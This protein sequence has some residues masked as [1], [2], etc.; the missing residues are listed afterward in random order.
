MAGVLLLLAGLLA[1]LVG[2]ALLVGS[3]PQRRLPAMVAPVGQVCECPPG[4]NP[5]KPGPVDQARPNPD[6]PAA[7]V[8]DRRAGRLVAVTS[9]ADAVETWTF[10]VCRNAWTRMHPDQEPAGL[11]EWDLFV[12]DVDSDVTVAVDRDDGPVWVYDLQADTWVRKGTGPSD[13]RLGAYDPV[14]GLVVVARDGDPPELWNYDVEA[15][16]WT[17][18]RLANGPLAEGWAGALAYDASVDQ[19]VAYNGEFTRLLNLRAGIWSTSGAAAPPVVGW[20]VAPTMAYDEAA[21]R[22]A[23]FLRVPLTAYD[24][25]ADRWVR[26]PDADSGWPHPG[27]P[28]PSRMVFD[29]VNRRLI[30]M[31][32][33]R[34]TPDID[35]PPGGVEALDLASG[36]RT[37]LLEPA[38]GQPAP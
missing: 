24:A 8:F 34:G 13:A 35:I 21:R 19:I 14:S 32:E 5:D 37:V 26:V 2:G 9:A 7:V 12:Y 18:I 17:P 28:Y 11:D 30:G 31:S 15:D 3:Q 29:A 38:E 20:M 23:L 6:A 25:T 33:W 36:E 1:A 4:S 16:T 27:W 10:D 22:T